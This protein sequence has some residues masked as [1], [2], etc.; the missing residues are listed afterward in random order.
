[1]ENVSVRSASRFWRQ[2][3]AAAR[4]SADHLHDAAAKAVILDIADKYERMATRAE[5]RTERRAET[6]G[7]AAG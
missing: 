4:I 2:K 6:F 7:A 1:M 5:R 3:A